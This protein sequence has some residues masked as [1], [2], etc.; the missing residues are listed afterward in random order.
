MVRLLP[1]VGARAGDAVDARAR[2]LFDG[3]VVAVNDANKAREEKAQ[4]E[5][6]LAATNARIAELDARAAVA[7]AEL[8]PELER[9][10]SALA[11]FL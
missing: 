7:R 2:K 8:G 3:A 9:A 4:L 5:A 6:Q 11:A 1:A 10:R